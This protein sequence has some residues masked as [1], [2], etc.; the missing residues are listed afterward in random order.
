MEIPR[1]VAAY[2]SR[3]DPRVNSPAMSRFV[4]IATRRTIARRGLAAA[5]PDRAHPRMVRHS[6]SLTGLCRR[7]L[8]RHAWENRAPTLCSSSRIGRRGQAQQKAEAFSGG[9]DA[10]NHEARVAICVRRTDGRVVLCNGNMLRGSDMIRK[11]P[12]PRSMLDLCARAQSKGS[13]ALQP[14][15]FLTRRSPRPA[16]RGETTTKMSR[17]ATVVA[18]G[19][20]PMPY[21]RGCELRK[22]TEYTRT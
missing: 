7:R 22:H 10:K 11:I 3:P 14:D 4:V 21:R 1:L 9:L 20:Q 2:A 17:H 16:A 12:R 5:G 18:R 13:S 19:R 15:K 8:G 6:M